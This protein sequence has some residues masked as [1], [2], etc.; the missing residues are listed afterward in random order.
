MCLSEPGKCPDDKTCTVPAFL[1]KTVEACEYELKSAAADCEHY[2]FNSETEMC[3]FYTECPPEASDKSQ[4]GARCD[5]NGNMFCL[6]HSN[7]IN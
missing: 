3:T 7:D 2:T 1:A 5:G 4:H 6:I